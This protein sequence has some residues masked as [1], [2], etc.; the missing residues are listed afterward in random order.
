MGLLSEA[1]V[2]FEGNPNENLGNSTVTELESKFEKIMPLSEEKC[3][4]SPVVTDLLER[5]IEPSSSVIDL[6]SKGVEE[7]LLPAFDENDGES[8]YGAADLD[9]KENVSS[10]L[11][12][13][14]IPCIEVG[15]GVEDSY[16]AVDSVSKENVSSMLQAVETPCV[17]DRNA[18]ENSYG[19]ADL[20]S[21]GNVVPGVEAGDGGENGN[22]SEVP[23][24]IENQV[25]ELVRIFLERKIIWFASY[26]KY[27]LGLFLFK[28]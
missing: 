4:I 10:M 5:E 24:S 15:N 16:E 17:E 27:F 6:V 9:S 28:F 14:E 18:V 19:A 23:E 20:V 11:Q 12:E 7:E 25:C 1:L 21:K 3:G 22:K 2:R 26:C 13:V 8:S